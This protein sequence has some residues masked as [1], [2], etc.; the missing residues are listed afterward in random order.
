M[1]PRHI[2][3]W[4]SLH[5][6][7]PTV[8]HSD[9]GGFQRTGLRLPGRAWVRPCYRRLAMG[10]THAVYILGEINGAAVRLAFAAWRRGY[11]FV[12]LNETAA[13]F[14]GAVLEPGVVAVYVHVHDFGALSDDGGCRT[15]PSTLSPLSSTGLGSRSRCSTA[16]KSRGTLGSVSAAGAPSG[17]RCPTSWLSLTLPRKC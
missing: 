1:R 15:R 14:R 13:L 8:R 3:Q 16:T 5:L 12:L 2:P 7:C 11:S 4:W 9:I 10:S 17:C 6:A